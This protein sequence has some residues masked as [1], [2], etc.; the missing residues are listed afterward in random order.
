MT[1]WR[2][3]S[4][5]TEHDGP[6]RPANATLH[7]M[8]ACSSRLTGG[9]GQ[10]GLQ[11]ASECLLFPDFHG[12]ES[13]SSWTCLSFSWES[14]NFSRAWCSFFSIF[15]MC[16]LKSQHW[17]LSQPHFPVVT[18]GLDGGLL[19]SAGPR[20]WDFK[21]FG[22][23]LFPYGAP[24][25]CGLQNVLWIAEREPKL[26]ALWDYRP[27]FPQDHLSFRFTESFQQ[28]GG[29]FFRGIRLPFG[30]LC[31]VYVWGLQR[32]DYNFNL[33]SVYF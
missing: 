3:S 21:S 28:S 6:R 9:G 8:S 15:S 30:G 7:P 5:V 1:K 23:P 2:D 33:F 20:G 25:D 26:V 16:G 13:L 32:E 10:K 24:S 27:G 14:S 17:K 18:K 12:K 31:S 4:E 22:Q 29:I 11:I 19:S